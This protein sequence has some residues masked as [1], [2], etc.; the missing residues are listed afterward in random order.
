MLA[1]IRAALHH[2]P[3]MTKEL[4]NVIT[5]LHGFHLAGQSIGSRI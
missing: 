3:I 4:K 5:N 1:T 2:R